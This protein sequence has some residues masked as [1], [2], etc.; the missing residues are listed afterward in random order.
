MG[1]RKPDCHSGAGQELDVVSMDCKKAQVSIEVLLAMLIVLVAFVM[2][3]A[4][5]AQLDSEKENLR[6]WLAKDVK[7]SR[8]QAIFGAI[9]LAGNRTDINGDDVEGNLKAYDNEIY[10]Y[11]YNSQANSSLPCPNF[12]DVNADSYSVSGKINVKNVY[13][14]LVIRNA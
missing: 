11:D 4:Y 8:Q 1:E 5:S 14:R 12:A 2:V 10:F 9:F 6:A 7:C 13:G 3:I